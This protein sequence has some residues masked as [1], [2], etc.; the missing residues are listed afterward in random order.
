VS[1]CLRIGNA[2]GDYA[3]IV[4]GSPVKVFDVLLAEVGEIIAKL[5]ELLRD[6]DILFRLAMR[7][8]SHSG[9]F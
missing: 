2:V 5:L 7:R 4:V 8:P 3:A 9:R 6:Q 1:G